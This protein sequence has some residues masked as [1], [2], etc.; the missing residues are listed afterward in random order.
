MLTSLPDHRAQSTFVAPGPRRQRRRAEGVH[1]VRRACAQ[2]AR[3]P[4][5]RVCRRC[6]PDESAGEKCQ[7]NLPH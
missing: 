3:R 4:Q 6:T 2:T 7:E 5:R 1:R